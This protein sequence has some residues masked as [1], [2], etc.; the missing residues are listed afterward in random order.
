MSIGFW[1]GSSL[2][3]EKNKVLAEDFVGKDWTRNCERISGK[4]QCG[5][6]FKNLFEETEKTIKNNREKGVQIFSVSAS[7]TGWTDIY[8]NTFDIV[9][10]DFYWPVR[11]LEEKGYIGVQK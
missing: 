9:A 1:N 5:D 11:W 10:M 3:Y 4:I 8:C 6:Y 2:V 7:L